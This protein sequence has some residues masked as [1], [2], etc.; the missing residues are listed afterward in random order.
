MNALHLALVTTTLCRGELIGVTR[1]PSTGIER[2]A[3]TGGRDRFEAEVNADRF[4]RSYRTL[5]CV[6]HRQTQPPI[7][8]GILREAAL[9]PLH[10][11]ESLCLERAESLAAEPHCL[12]RAFE[13]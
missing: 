12:A 6:L 3:V 5:H 1:G 10:V 4:V 13:A 8:D 2:L 7:A 11:L 9:L